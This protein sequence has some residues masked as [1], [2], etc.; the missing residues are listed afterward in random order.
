MEPQEHS[1]RFADPG[2]TIY[3]LMADEVLIECPRCGKCATHKPVTRDADT[4]NWFAP[5][6]LVCPHCGLTRDWQE[7]QIYRSW[8]ESP[9]RDDNFNE[10]LWIRGSFGANEI[11]AYNW[12]HLK[13][14]EKYVAAI[15]R[16]HI[17]DGKTGWANKS[18]V[19]RLPK[20][21]GSRKNRDDIL[22][23][24]DRIKRERSTST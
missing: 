21:I 7:K 11:W 5:R 23:T 4:R 18:F 16:Q 19:N 14:I 1:E 6:R 9:A 12:R 10:A 17:R 13:L 15:H 20:W 3:S 24:I 2:D 22:A 8:R